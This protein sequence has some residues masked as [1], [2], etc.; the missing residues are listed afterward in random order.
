MPKKLNFYVA[1]GQFRPYLNYFRYLSYHL[2]QYLTP[3]EEMYWNQVMFRNFHPLQAWTFDH[4]VV[5]WRLEYISHPS[6]HASCESLPFSWN[7]LIWPLDP[8]TSKLISLAF[9]IELLPIPG[10]G[11]ICCSWI[12]VSKEINQ[13]T[14]NI[15][16][17]SF[18]VTLCLTPLVMVLCRWQYHLIPLIQMEK[19]LNNSMETDING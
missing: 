5:K 18:W 13:N 7:L 4:G 6:V 11:Y 8:V 12:S 1:A 3:D 19:Y 17:H 14:F 10:Q 9:S 16:F 15:F 2:F